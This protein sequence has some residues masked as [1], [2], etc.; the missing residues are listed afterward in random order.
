MLGRSSYRSLMPEWDIVF[1]QLVEDVWSLKRAWCLGSDADILCQPLSSSFLD[2]F[3][4]PL[5]RGSRNV[6]FPH[7]CCLGLPFGLP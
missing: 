7:I 1:W 2:A 5:G 3:P 4:T 6:A